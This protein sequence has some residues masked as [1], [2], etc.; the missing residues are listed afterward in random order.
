MNTNYSY[1]NAPAHPGMIADQAPRHIVA[2]LLDADANFGIGVVTGKQLGS[3]VKIPTAVDNTFEKFEGVLINHGTVEHEHLTG[4]VKV[5]AGTTCSVMRYGVV[6]VRIEPEKEIA[7]GDK[8]K[9][10]INGPHAGSFTNSTTA[11]T[12]LD[13]PGRFLEVS[14]GIAKI[15]LNM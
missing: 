1:V 12:A 3:S 13:I 5:R 6:W 2:R 4:A 14:D 9:L 10:L 7:Y 8:L 15:E 11:E